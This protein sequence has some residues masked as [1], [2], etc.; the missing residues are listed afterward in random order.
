MA[1][2]SIQRKQ[3]SPKSDVYAYGVTCT[4]IL[5]RDEPYPGAAPVNVAVA[6]IRDGLRPA[7]PDWCPQMLQEL[8]WRCLDA[9]PDPRPSMKQVQAELSQMMAL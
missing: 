7:I 4:E 2:E 6:V 8:I 1:P 9:M 5:T 3:Y